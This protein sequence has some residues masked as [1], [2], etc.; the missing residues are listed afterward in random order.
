MSACN[1]TQNISPNTCIGDSLDTINANFSS[2]DLGLCDVPDVLAGTGTRTVFEAN[3]QL[4]TSVKVFTK[5]SFTY[6]TSFEGRLNVANEQIILS[7]ATP[8]TVTSFPKSS[9]LDS[10]ATFSTV[11]LTDST[12]KV[13]LFWTASGTDLLT[14]YDTNSASGETNDSSI[15]FN[16]P[17]TSLLSSGDLVYVGGEFTTVGGQVCNKFCILNV[18]GNG[19]GTLIGNPLSA[20]GDL[21]AKGTVSCIVNSPERN[22]LAV[23]GSFEGNGRGLIIKSFDNIYAFYVNGVVNDLAVVNDLDGIGSYLY[24]GGKF[25]YINYG[26]ESRSDASGLRVYTNGLAKIDLNILTAYPNSSIV[27]LFCESIKNLFEGPVAINSLAS[28][29]SVLYA[30]GLFEIKSGD[31]TT[32]R[33]LAIINSNGTQN[34]NWNP[35]VG[36]E[37]YTLAT[38]DSASKFLYVGGDFTTFYTGEDFYRS[39]RRSDGTEQCNNAICF[40][41]AVPNKPSLQTSWKPRFNGP[42]TKF[43]FHSSQSGANSYVYCYGRFTKVNSKDVNY[44]VALEKSDLGNSLAG[45][46]MEWYVRLEKAPNLINQGICRYGDTLLIGGNFTK[47]NNKNRFYLAKVSSAEENTIN[48]A[49]SAVAW[50]LN[51]QICSPGMSLAMNSTNA[52]A[53]TSYPGPFGIVNETSFELDQQKYGDIIEGTLLR[54]SIKRP[55][56]ADNLN[57]SAHVLGWKVD[58]N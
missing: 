34:N 37:V 2:L 13:S 54:F 24:V 27:K 4:H 19:A 41:A 56:A 33:N 16:G 9:T 36:G 12:P 35:I 21:G 29:S 52:L 28:L 22:L 23:G 10:I 38:D 20:L 17:I 48:S 32:A 31:V 11:S 55:K 7:D 1:Y 46:L 39:P 14:I 49:L 26:T 47:V 6:G 53:L 5:N 40:Q 42:V 50:E 8:L 30:G 3:E 18:S 44:I 58:F 25:D 45:N 15:S 57:A 43:A 51:A